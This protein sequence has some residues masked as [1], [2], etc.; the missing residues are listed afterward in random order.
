[1]ESLLEIQYDRVANVAVFCYIKSQL[2]LR[3]IQPVFSVC[4]L[5]PEFVLYLVV[6]RIWITDRTLELLGRTNV[7]QS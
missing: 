3:F 6:F 2:K 4:H 7:R 5:T 1:M